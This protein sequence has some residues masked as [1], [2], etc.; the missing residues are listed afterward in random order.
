MYGWQQT[1]LCI[2]GLL[3][4][5]VLY[6]V[7]VWLVIEDQVWAMFAFPIVV[8]PLAAY[9][10]RRWIEEVPTSGMFA[11]K[12]QSKAFVIG[13]AVVLPFAFM[14]ATI[15]WQRTE[16]AEHMWVLGAVLLIGFVVAIGFRLFDRSRYQKTARTKLAF[17]SPTKLWHDFVIYPVL[18]GVMIW[19]GVPLLIEWSMWTWLTLASIAIW[20]LLGLVD[21]MNQPNPEDQHPAWNPKEFRAA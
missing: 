18:F 3:A 16:L 11:L 20:F 12:T 7:G 10:V 6:L 2:R 21:A 8:S 1:M 14:F 5:A 9:V 19:A 17:H 4:A 13:D 15:G